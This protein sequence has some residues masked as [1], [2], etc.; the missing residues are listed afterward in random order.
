M[1]EAEWLTCDEPTVLAKYGFDRFNH[2]KFRWLA[3]DMGK[4]IHHF[5]EDDE[6][7][8]FDAYAGWV[9]GTGSHLSDLNLPDRI[10]P[11][12]YPFPR[13]SSVRGFI[14]NLE[15]DNPMWA[16]FCAVDCLKYPNSPYGPNA[17]DEAAWNANS[18]L[19]QN[20]FCSAFRDIV[21][22]PF[23]PVAFDSAWLSSTAR[24][25]AEAIY[26]DRAFD[27]LPILAD[28]LQDA[29][30]ENDDILSHCRGDGPHVRGCWVVDLVLGKE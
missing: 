8:I 19:V 23:R 26:D 29:G 10:I 3:V 9:A 27:R 15:N 12:D 14:A 18:I 28:A 11:I 6:R 22:N 21:G 16:A 20:E 7:T 24:G 25:I 30:C 2:Q 1:T 13:T 4:R 5:F 17:E